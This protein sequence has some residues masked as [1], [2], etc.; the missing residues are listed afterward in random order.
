M[1]ELAEV[2]FE[3]Y[4]REEYSALVALGAWL[5]RDWAMGEDLAQEALSTT[6]RRW[7]KISAY[8]RPGRFTR[9]VMVNLASNERRRRKRERRAVSRLSSQGSPN[10]DLDVVFSEEN[11]AL[12]HE[13]GS[14]P[15]Q[16]RATVALR[17]VDGLPTSEIAET[18]ECA[19][20]TVRVHLHRARQR[21]ANRLG[22]AADGSEPVTG[23]EESR[24]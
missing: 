9:R 21:L 22:S 7:H 6:Q 18:L 5:T 10:P 3:Q 23:T 8:D 11:K 16:Q 15:A 13:L 12:W 24:R 17:Y 14:L 19:E 1:N 4:F 2:S 20:A